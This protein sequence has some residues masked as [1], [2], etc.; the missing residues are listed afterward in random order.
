MKK[1]SGKMKS[2]KIGV[3]RGTKDRLMLL[4]NKLGFMDLNAVVIHL[5][6]RTALATKEDIKEL[7]GIAMNTAT[8]PAAIPLVVPKV[9]T[10]ETNE[11]NPNLREVTCPGCQHKFFTD[12]TLPV[13]CPVCGTEGSSNQ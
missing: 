8:N 10:F 2:I 12:I 5:L 6:D 4:R 13:K 3:E 7:F 1:R 9:N 11:K